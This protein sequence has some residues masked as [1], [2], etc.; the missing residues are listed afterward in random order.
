MQRCVATTEECPRSTRVSAGTTA[1]EVATTGLSRED[2][3][4]LRAAEGEGRKHSPVDAGERD[5]ALKHIIQAETPQDFSARRSLSDVA[6]LL[7]VLSWEQVLLSKI[8]KAGPPPEKC[9]GQH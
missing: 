9:Q 2:G 8:N 4:H 1:A 6:L 3:G 7:L 5:T